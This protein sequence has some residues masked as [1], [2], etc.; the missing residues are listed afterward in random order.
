MKNFT[1]AV[2][3]FVFIFVLFVPFASAVSLGG[4]GLSYSG[5]MGTDANGATAMQS[6]TSANAVI[7]INKNSS[8][9]AEFWLNSG[10]VAAT[11][12]SYI[13]KFL[14]HPLYPYAGV[15][16]LISNS[17]S[18]SLKG[19]LEVNFGKFSAYAGAGYINSFT[20]GDRGLISFEGGIRYYINK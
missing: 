17:V 19:G 16:V 9:E 13:Y 11:R 14:M 18:M 6:Y 15:G 20:A 5:V 1:K 3:F 10:G 12:I 2:I 4:G 7:E 8:V